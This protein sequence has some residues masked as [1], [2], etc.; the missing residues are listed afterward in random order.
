MD[1][2]EYFGCICYCM[3]HVARFTYSYPEKGDDEEDNVIYFTITARNLFN[4][5]FPY[6]DLR[7]TNWPYNFREYFCDNIL[8]RIPIAIKHICTSYY[9]RKY[10]LTDSFDFRTEKL[11][12][13]KAVLTNLTEDNS[14]ENFQSVLHL[15]NDHWQLRF[16]IAKPYKEMPYCLGWDIQFI[17]RNIFG[18]I[19]DALKYVFG[20]YYDVQEFEID[21]KTATKLRGMI[22]VVSKLSEDG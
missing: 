7:P 12:N 13:M 3:N 9:T 2:E 14:D 11:M 18:R 4:R 21:K 17:P 15:E 20:K 10:G 1:V 16:T 19:K 5:I 6:I 8:R 22:D